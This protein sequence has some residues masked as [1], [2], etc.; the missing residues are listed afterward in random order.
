MSVN[1]W[2]IDLAQ[3]MEGAD[4]PAISDDF[5][6]HKCLGM[7]ALGNFYAMGTLLSQAS[8]IREVLLCLS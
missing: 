6:V 8:R 4:Q 1:D 2:F 3:V 5:P 7:C